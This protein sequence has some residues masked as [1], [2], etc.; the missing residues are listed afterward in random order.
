MSLTG[1]S[2][3]YDFIRFVSSTVASL[4]VFSLYSMV[5]GLMVA[6][7]VNEYAMSAVN[8]AIPYTNALFSIAITFAVGSSTLIAFYLAQ[9]KQREANALFSQNFVVL[10]CIGTILTLFTFTFMEPFACLLGADEY[11]LPY[12]MDYLRGLVP[13]SVCFLISYNL[14]VLVKTDGFPRFAMFTVITGC[15]ANCVMDYIAIFWLGLGAFGAAAATGLSQ[16]L[17]CILYF[18]HFFGKSCT[19]RLQKFKFEPHIY[20]RLIPIGFADGITELC[21]GLM[22]FLF[23]RTVL[24]CIGTDGVVTYTVIAYVN[25]LVIN[26][27]VGISQ[28]SQPLISYHYGKGESRQSLTFLRYGL[29]AVCVIAPLTFVGLYL[30]APQIVSTYLSHASNRLI[31]DS[32]QAF[33]HYSISYLIVGWNIV[34]GGFMTAIERPLP[35]I[36][37]SVGRGFAL[38]SLI[39]LCLAALFGGTALWYT[40]IISELLCCGISLAFLSRVRKSLSA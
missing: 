3:K 2:P 28:G 37:I 24:R 27:M 30:F 21:T 9:K 5:D 23:N 19:F 35:S 13:F 4:M 10:L 38:Q 39:L 20:K 8:L 17:T 16:L 26:I 31:Q 15:L 40:P 34:I 33:R 6:L 11:T 25:T 7:G 29:T 1:K 36:S 12:V 18:I 14:E 32:I 22:I